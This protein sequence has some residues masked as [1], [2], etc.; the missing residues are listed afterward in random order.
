MIG[1]K[2]R[3]AFILGPHIFYY[4]RSCRTVERAHECRDIVSHRTRHRIGSIHSRTKEEIDQQITACI[5]YCQCQC[6]KNLI[7]SERYH[8]FIIL[9]SWYK[10]PSHDIM[11]ITLC[12]I[13]INHKVR[14]GGQT[15]HCCIKSQGV[16]FIVKQ[17]YDKTKPQQGIKDV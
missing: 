12:Q 5:T 6:K 3:S 10:L 2:R 15:H 16:T 9:P 14:Q 8:S 4:L 13:M 11:P 1:Y 17:K 7:S